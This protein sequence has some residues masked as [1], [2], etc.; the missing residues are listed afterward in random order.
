MND[1]YAMFI[2]TL[3]DIPTSSPIPHES[4]EQFERMLD[5]PWTGR[6]RV[7]VAMAGERPLGISWLGYYPTTG[8][9]FTEM[10]GVA[11][12][13]RGKGVGTALKLKTIEQALALGVSSILTENDA[14]NAPILRI[15]RAFGY[16]PVREALSY[17]RPA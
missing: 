7:W 13:G 6:N 4:Q 1:V 16:Q 2:E 17:R 5:R 15:N 11:R 8:I 12:A 10:T 3:S 14:D 9:V